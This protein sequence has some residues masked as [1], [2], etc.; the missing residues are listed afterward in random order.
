MDI[1]VV[2]FHF[3]LC[4]SLQAVEGNCEEKT[5]RNMDRKTDKPKTMNKVI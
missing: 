4:V 2:F 3:L 5:E 1:S